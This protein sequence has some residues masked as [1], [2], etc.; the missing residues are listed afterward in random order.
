MSAG[1]PR[2]QGIAGLAQR[3]EERV[4]AAKAER[5]LLA[6]EQHA[7]FGAHGIGA[8]TA[9]FEVAPLEGCRAG[10]F[11]S[12]QGFSAGAEQVARIGKALALDHDDKLGRRGGRRARGSGQGAGSASSCQRHQ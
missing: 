2:G 10:G 7:I 9:D 6:P 1:Q 12:G 3:G 5:F 4:V 8:K 11:E